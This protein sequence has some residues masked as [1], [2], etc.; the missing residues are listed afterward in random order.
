[1]SEK[2]PSRSPV[3]YRG[4]VA[5]H[6]GQIRIAGDT[7]KSRIKRIG[8]ASLAV[9]GPLSDPNYRNF[10]EYLKENGHPLSEGFG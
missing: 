4:R 2:E 9:A 1:M 10:E 7:Y 6:Y 8:R 5:L 3:G